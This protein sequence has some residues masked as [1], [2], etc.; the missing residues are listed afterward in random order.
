MEFQKNIPDYEGN[1]PDSGIDLARAELYRKMSGPRILDGLKDRKDT[2]PKIEARENI[3]LE[4]IAAKAGVSLEN[5]DNW[6]KDKIALFTKHLDG[7]VSYPSQEYF[8]LIDDLYNIFIFSQEN[9]DAIGESPWLKSFQSFEEFCTYYCPNASP[10][11]QAYLAHNIQK[12]VEW[13]VYPSREVSIRPGSASTIVS[14]NKLYMGKGNWTLMPEPFWDTPG[15]GSFVEEEVILE[16]I[17]LIKNGYKEPDYSHASGSEALENIGKQQAILS[18]AEALKSGVKPKTGEFFSYINHDGNSVTGRDTGLESVYA[19]HGGPRYGYH[20][21]RWF[22]EFF[23]NF[24]INKQHQEEFMA[25]TD[26]RYG[27]GENRKDLSADW[28]GE[29]ILIGN[30]VPLSSIDYVYYWK[31]YHDVI[32]KWADK[33]LPGIN[34][35]SL[36][37]AQ[38]LEK[39][40][41][42]INTIALQEGITPEEAWAK[43]IEISK[44]ETHRRE[45][46]PQSEYSIEFVNSENVG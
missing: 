25:K 31:L 6:L 17:S 10:H 35:I 3:S 28:G 11:T 34:L 43:L 8:P 13:R 23:I 40:G 9:P 37:A 44:T 33:N 41:N 12:F 7:E 1:N 29:G 27:H 30:K 42:S 45:V 46:L 4:N 5:L 14:D 16:I 22:D 36:E 39:Y 2:I 19:D 24:G 38:V 21:I 26:F 20:I 18:A 32:K 15:S